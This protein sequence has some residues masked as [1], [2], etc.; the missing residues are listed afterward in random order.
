MYLNQVFE[1]LQAAG[2][3]VNQ[4]SQFANSKCVYF[5]HVV[6]GGTISPMQ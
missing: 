2:L 4:K 6:G 3:C 1:R 5:R